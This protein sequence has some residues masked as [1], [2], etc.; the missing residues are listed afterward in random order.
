MIRSHALDAHAMPTSYKYMLM[1][2]IKIKSLQSY[3]IITTYTAS[4]FFFYINIGF[5][6]ITTRERAHLYMKR[7]RTITLTLIIGFYH[8]YYIIHYI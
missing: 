2:I 6:L 1:Y 7:N 4:L 3:L 5:P 8:I